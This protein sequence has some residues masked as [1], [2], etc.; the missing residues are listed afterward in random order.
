MDQQS[1]GDVKLP[2]YLPLPTLRHM[3][4]LPDEEID[5]LRT[6]RGTIGVTFGAFDLT[7]AGHIV[8]FWEAKARRIC[9]FLFVGIQSNP[10]LDRPSKNAPSET[11]LERH[12]RI[13]KNPDVNA[14]AMYDTE[15]ELEEFLCRYARKSGGF[16]DVRILDEEYRDKQ[17]TGKGLPIEV[18]YNWRTHPWSTSTLKKRIHADVVDSIAA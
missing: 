7:H 16:I 1:F 11:L 8:M 10:R 17:Y 14:Y 13:H 5:R 3:L 12:I 4:L 9:D 2:D 18:H 6:F 15:G